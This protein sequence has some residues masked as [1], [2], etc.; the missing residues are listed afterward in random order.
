[1]NH[2][3]LLFIFLFA[4]GIF[5]FYGV[6]NNE[7]KIKKLEKKIWELERRQNEKTDCR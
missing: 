3:D 5:I 1:M 7:A 2:L 6:C 4:F